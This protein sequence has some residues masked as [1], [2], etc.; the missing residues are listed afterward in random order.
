MDRDEGG[1]AVDLGGKCAHGVDEPG[2]EHLAVARLAE[3]GGDPAELGAQLTRPRL[4]DE[5]AER[6]QDAAQPPGGHPEL[7]DG[8]GQVSAHPL[9]L[10]D[11]RGDLRADVVAARRRRRGP[12]AWGGRRR[13]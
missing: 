7:V 12:S 6:L 13:R 2:L 1:G 10:R 4:V 9:V 3:H 5:R 11:D 8:V